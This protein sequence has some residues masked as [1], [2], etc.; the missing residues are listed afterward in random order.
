MAH[1]LPGAHMSSALL[2]V[3]SS[4]QVG[5]HVVQVAK[6]MEGRWTVRIDDVA[7]A[8]SYATQADA[9]EAGVREADRMDRACAVTQ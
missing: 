1:V 6:V 3:P 4:F 9:W 7:L 8:Q 2:A 5:S